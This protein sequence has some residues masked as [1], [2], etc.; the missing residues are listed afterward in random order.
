MAGTGSTAAAPGVQELR[1]KPVL[2]VHANLVKLELEQPCGL[3]RGAVGVLGADDH[4]AVGL[5]RSGDEERGEDAGGGRVLDV[6][7]ELLGKP[8]ELA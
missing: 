3:L 7:P 1:A 5:E 4:S 6:P 8:D 2:V